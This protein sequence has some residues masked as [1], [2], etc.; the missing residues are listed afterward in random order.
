LGGGDIPDE[1]DA[2]LILLGPDYPHVKGQNDS[3]ARQE[4]RTILDTRG[5][6]PRSYK[7]SLVFLAGDA[8]RLQDLQSA[9]RQFLAWKSIWEER[10]KLNLDPFQSDQADTKRKN[11]EET[12]KVRI[13]EAY[14]WLLVPSQSEPRGEPEWTEIRLQGADSLSQR[15]SKKL[16]NEEML[17]VQMGGVRLRLELDKIPLW[18]GEDV[19][20]R[21]LVEDFATYLYLPRLRDPDV[22][23]AA[24]REGVAQAQWQ[25][26]TFAYA[27]SKNAEGRYLGLTGGRSSSI[28]AEG[29]T[30]LVKPDVAA[31]QLRK[32]M[33]AKAREA[34]AQHGGTSRPEV[35]GGF[36]GT[37]STDGTSTAAGTPPVAAPPTYRRFHGSVQIDALR[38]GRD[39]GRVA[40]EV[41]QH[42]TKLVGADVQ[43]T[44]EIQAHFQDGAPD[45]TMM[46]VKENCRALNFDGFGFEEE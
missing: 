23:V 25:T 11:A 42:L 6:N 24:I 35:P 40:D 3:P 16:R 34:G 46:D 19:P 14:Q 5:S 44:I 45:K 30:L 20:I 33:E 17:L 41:I 32:D 15:A 38:V 26:E 22:L 37:T 2:R 10:I 31:E 27:Q 39:A 13:P 12:V 28:Q 29:G 36:G 8:T 43:V 4:A 9:V 7:N 18:R 21:Q 1:H